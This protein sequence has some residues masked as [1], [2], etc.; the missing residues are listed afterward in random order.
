MYRE[1]DWSVQACPDSGEGDGGVDGVVFEILDMGYGNAIC[2]LP[3]DHEN[4]RPD[5]GHLIAFGGRGSLEI[6]SGERCPPQ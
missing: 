6:H 1:A 2:L 5:V 4:A 3:S